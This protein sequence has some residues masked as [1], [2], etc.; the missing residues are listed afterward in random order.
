VLPRRLK[1]RRFSQRMRKQTLLQRL[2]AGLAT[3]E[4][5]QSKPTEIWRRLKSLTPREVDVLC[6]VVGGQLNREIAAELGLT[7]RTIKVHRGRVMEKLAVQSTAQLFPMV[8][9][10]LRYFPSHK[11]RPALRMERAIA[12]GFPKVMI[13]LNRSNALYGHTPVAPSSFPYSLSLLVI[14]R[15]P[16]PIPFHLC[17]LENHITRVWRGSPQ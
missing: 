12:A 17:V 1:F 16:T 8:L 10:A 6:Y 3:N 7:E 14:M 2:V 4:G 9:R 11:P 15:E 13:R 5:V